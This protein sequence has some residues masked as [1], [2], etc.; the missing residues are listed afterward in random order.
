V[1]GNLLPWS[2]RWPRLRVLLALQGFPP[3]LDRRFGVELMTPNPIKQICGGT[4][5]SVA[6]TQPS[7]NL[8]GDGSRITA[9]IAADRNA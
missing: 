5:A 8:V 1:R 2:N 9:A 7:G 4:A 6:F 3:I